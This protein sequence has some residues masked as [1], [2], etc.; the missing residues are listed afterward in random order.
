LLAF[1]GGEKVRRFL[2]LAFVFALS[3][4]VAAC[5]RSEPAHEAHAEEGHSHEHH[6]SGATEWGKATSE[7][8]TAEIGCGGCMYKMAGA[9]GCKTA[10]KLDGKTYWVE[11]LEIDAHGAGLCDATKQAEIAG[12]IE[13]GKYTATY[14]KLK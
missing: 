4:A 7:T 12:K 11:G 5:T 1:L 6:A 2:S 9:A 14:L 13:N 10:V 8:Q 3:L